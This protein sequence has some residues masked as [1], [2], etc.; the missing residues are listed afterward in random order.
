M[1]KGYYTNQNTNQ[2]TILINNGYSYN[3]KIKRT[4]KNNTES[5]SNIYIEKLKIP[6]TSYIINAIIKEFKTYDLN[7]KWEILVH[8]YIKLKQLNYILYNPIYIINI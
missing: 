6:N 7:I 3:I 1:L 5:L 8:R 2:I 4:K